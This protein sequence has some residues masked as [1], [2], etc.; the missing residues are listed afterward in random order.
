MKIFF[1]ILLAALSFNVRSELVATGDRG[2]DA[3]ATLKLF[4]RGAINQFQVKNNLY[5]AGAATGALWYSFDQDQ[6]L[7]DLARTKKMNKAV[8]LVGELGVVAA[9]PALQ[10]GVYELARNKHNTHAM[11]FMMEYTATVYLVLI[12][13][14]L[15][16]VIDIHE[17]PET[18][19]TNFWEKAFRGK[20]SF[21]SGHMVPYAALAFKTLQFYGPWWSVLPFGLT[22]MASLQRVQDGKHYTSDVVGSFFL[23]AFASEGVRMAAQYRHN[24]GFYRWLYEREAQV[25]FIQHEGVL[26]PSLVLKF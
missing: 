11:Q 17:R 6:R 21:P 20:S 23:A 3:K 15:L 7:S 10:W 24:H 1:I 8:S 18:T 4:Y 9:F 25:G 26:G 22:A 5:Y 12:E 19:E 13:S 14:A 2:H 16:S